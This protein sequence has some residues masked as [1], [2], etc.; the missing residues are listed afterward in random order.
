MKRQNNTP[1]VFS[2][3]QDFGL[4]A[5]SI[6]DGNISNDGRQGKILTSE[7]SSNEGYVND[8]V[9]SIFSVVSAERETGNKFSSYITIKYNVIIEPTATNPGYFGS[10]IIKE[11]DAFVI[12]SSNKDYVRGIVSK[13]SNFTYSSVGVNYE[14]TYVLLCA[15]NQGD[16]AYIQ[17]N[18]SFIW[19]RQIFK[20]L[21]TYNEA[22]P[23]ANISASFNRSTS[24]I[25]FYWDNPNRNSR[26]YNIQIREAS[27]SDSPTYIDFKVYG[28][29]SNSKTSITPFVNSVSTDISTFKIL[30]PGIDMNSNRSIDIIG[31][32]TG[33][34]WETV[35][36]NNG[37]LMINE[38]SIYDAPVGS[39]SIFIYVRE[40]RPEYNGY[41]SPN[42]NSFIQ[43][44]P[45]LGSTKNF[46]VGVNSFISDR[47][48]ELS[49]YDA[50]TGLPV[51]ITPAWSSS[52]IRSKI[53][54]HDGIRKINNGTGYNSTKIRASVKVIPEN[55]KAYWD[56]SILGI[57][58]PGQSLMAWKVSAVYDEENKYYTE[59]TEED[60]IQT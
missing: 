17:A 13:I 53:K 21:S 35:L 7:I 9:A 44:L 29:T 10:D 27:V 15:I 59:W 30:E 55:V 42:V 20:D 8:Y 5:P 12:T 40:T 16:P 38:F 47:E 46:Y 24:D 23:P 31:T 45:V 34:L 37:S 41:P 36:D 28:N 19:K 50:D 39:S 6:E 4:R 26:E 58:L 18:D 2:K 1:K 48:Y 14:F 49:I 33:A 43:G 60:Y 54:T 51:I 56:S 22:T 52:V 32:G 11:N 25:Y 3:Y 57:L